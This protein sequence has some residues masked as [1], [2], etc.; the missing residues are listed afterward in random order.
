MGWI[1]F[2]ALAVPLV[3]VIAWIAAR[4]VVRAHRA[5]PARSAADQGP[6]HGHGARARDRT[7]CRRCGDGWSRPIRRSSCP[8]APAPTRPPSGR[9]G[10]VGPGAAGGARRPR[11]GGRRVHRALPP[12][13]AQLRTV[14]ERFGPEGIWAAVR[15]VSES[16]LRDGA[17]AATVDDVFGRPA[18]A[19]AA[20]RT[21]SSVASWRAPAS[22]STMFHLGD[23]DLGRTG[24]VIEATSRAR[25]ELERE[26]A[27]AA[28]RMAR[29]R[30]DAD[31][32][33]LVGAEG[34]A[35]A[36]RYREVD[37][38]R[39]LARGTERRR[40][41]PAR[42]RGRATGRAGRG[43]GGRRG[44]SMTAATSGAT[45][46]PHPRGPRRR[47]ARRGHHRVG[48]VRVSGHAMERR[49][50]RARP[51]GVG[52]AGRG[53]PAVRA[54][55]P[56]RLLRQQH[57]RPV[58]PRRVG[59]N[60]RLQEFFKD[61]LI[62]PAFLPRWSSGSRRSPMA[63]A[64]GT[65]SSDQEYLEEQL[66]RYRDTEARPQ[67]MTVEAEEA[68]SNA[69]DYVLDDAA[70][71]LGAVLRRADD[72]VPG[73]LRP[74]DAARRV[75]GADRLRRLPPRR[76]ARSPD[77][78]IGAPTIWRARSRPPGTHAP[79]GR[80]REPRI[81]P[82]RPRRGCRRTSGRWRGRPGV[83]GEAVGAAAVLGPPAAE[84]H[85]DACRRARASV[86]GG[87]GTD[88]RRG[89]CGRRPRRRRRCRA[90]RRRRG[91]S[92]SGSPARR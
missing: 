64:R 60:E 44:R 62:R 15:D 67:A 22:S 43:P 89:R 46:P 65:C 20:P 40:A 61:S 88:A 56:D 74:G 26:E 58:R 54:G 55:D 72:V 16:A 48:L 92:R 79:G 24:E 4:R 37:S 6:G 45:Q 10:A 23:V 86:T 90:P 33:P 41:G 70:A 57:G 17:G 80:E 59:G 14:H 9:P 25:H 35:L 28:M 32:A 13:P 29:A 82:A 2:L 50:E 21:T 18:G 84:R 47:P 76:P 52:P 66:E 73:P 36:L 27:E 53:G 75:G 78:R 77:G 81:R 3:G 5:G 91:G 34:T 8:T 31:V 85:G 68:G 38:W 19:A 39:E 12:R 71:G 87:G 49:G 30:I 7:G 83:A 69:D 11:R 51:A 42:G 1:I 63:A